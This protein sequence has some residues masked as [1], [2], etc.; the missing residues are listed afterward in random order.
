M[1]TDCSLPSLGK[2]TL[3]RLLTVGVEMRPGSGTVFARKFLQTLTSAANSGLRLS[4]LVCVRV[5]P[6]LRYSFV[7]RSEVNI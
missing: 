2:K 5:G 3:D 6:Q 7:C 1:R 4:S